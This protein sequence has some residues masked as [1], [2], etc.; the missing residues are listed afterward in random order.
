[1]PCRSYRPGTL[2]LETEFQTA[3]GRAVIIDFMPPIVGSHLVR[4]VL[5]LSGSVTFRTETVMRFNYGASVP[6]VERLSDGSLSAVAG[7]E[8]LVLRSPI[9]LAGE[10]LK[11]IGEFTVGADTRVAQ[12]SDDSLARA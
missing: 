3:T 4:I 10:D 2:V 7:P 12:V 6:W 9:R 5:G 1:M 8:R 11:T